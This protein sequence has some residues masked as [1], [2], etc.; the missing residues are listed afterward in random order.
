MQRDGKYLFTL[1]LIF[2]PFSVTNKFV[3][4]R[5]RSLAIGNIRVTQSYIRVS[6]VVWIP[7]EDWM[8]IARH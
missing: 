2:I 8:A 5:L 7:L 1:P 3:D 4:F 6:F